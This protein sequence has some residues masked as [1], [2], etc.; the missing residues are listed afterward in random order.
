MVNRMSA[1]ARK[2]WNRR[3]LIAETLRVITLTRVKTNDSNIWVGTEDLQEFWKVHTPYSMRTSMTGYELD[4]RLKH[5]A[6]RPFLEKQFIDKVGERS[7]RVRR[8][9]YKITDFEALDEYI[10]LCTS[11]KD[12]L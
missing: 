7:Q 8:I 4:N 5:I 1:K 11:T 3:I 9:Y 2:K 12:K 6:A 10:M